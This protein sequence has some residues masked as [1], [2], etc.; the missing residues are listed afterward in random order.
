MAIT[1]GWDNSER[2]VLVYDF[3]EVWTWDE[4]FQASQ[5]DDDLLE[6]INYTVHQLFDMRKTRMIPPNPLARMENLAQEIRP[7]IGLMV[8]VGGTLWFQ[9]VVDIFHNFFLSRIPGVK[10]L[11]FVRSVDEGRAIIAQY[12]QEQV[13]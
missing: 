10:G 7:T 8:F 3:S 11:Y 12:T 5:E 13:G 9:T 1:V 4:L 2:T 6:G